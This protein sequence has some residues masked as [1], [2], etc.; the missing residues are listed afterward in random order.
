MEIGE[1]P[2]ISFSLLNPMISPL[3]LRSTGKVRV[4]R[5]DN[6]LSNDRKVIRRS[7]GERLRRCYITC[8][9][10]IVPEFV[11]IDTNGPS[12]NG[13]WVRAIE[14]IVAY[15][16]RNA[17]S[18]DLDLIRAESEQNSDPEFQMH[19]HSE[20][21]NDVENPF[22]FQSDQGQGVDWAMKLSR[23]GFV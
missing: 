9:S 12:R 5:Q 17:K 19:L 20:V 1:A 2:S 14:G 6:E 3:Y 23:R 4:C 13:D 15:P 18:A 16:S 22:D 10:R 11:G 21:G 7:N 8:P